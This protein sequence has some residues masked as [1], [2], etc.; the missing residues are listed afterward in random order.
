MLE[1]LNHLFRSCPR[2][3]EVWKQLMS[4]NK[5]EETNSLPFDQWLN[6]NLSRS[7]MAVRGDHWRERFVVCLW[8]IWTWRNDD[9]VFGNCER[10]LREK[11]ATIRTY[12][13]E[14]NSAFCSNVVLQ[15]RRS[16]TTTIWVGWEP[17]QRGWY[18]LNIDGCWKR[19][20]NLARGD[21]V[22]DL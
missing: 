21:G 20:A 2:A 18:V 4:G 11:T 12:L 17:P 13:K 3:G 15:S 16:I 19:E 6:W 22:L 14:V 8:W 10:T 7:G 1:D 5:W 9:A